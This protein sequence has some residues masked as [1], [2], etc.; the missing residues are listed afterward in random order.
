MSLLQPHPSPQR[1][2]GHDVNDYEIGKRFSL[3]IINIMN[4]DGTLNAAAGPYAGM[5]RFAARKALWADMEAQGLALKSEPYQAGGWW[6][7]CGWVGG[8]VWKGGQYGGAG[9][10]AQERVTPGGWEG[11]GWPWVL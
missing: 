1:P 10:C 11:G 5:E 6:C 3:E 4:D 8:W 2:A 9:A 7:A